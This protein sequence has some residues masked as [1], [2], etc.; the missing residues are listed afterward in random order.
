[1][2]ALLA[3]AGRL[4]SKGM[5][6][7][8]VFGQGVHPTHDCRDYC[9]YCTFRSDPGEPGA[10]RCPRR[11]PRALQSGRKAGRER[12]P[13]LFGDSPKR[14]F[15]AS[16]FAEA[17]GQRTT[18]GYLRDVSDSWSMRPD[19]CRTP[20]PASWPS[21][22]WAPCGRS[23]PAWGSCWRACPSGSLPWRRARS[24]ARQGAG[25]P[26]QDHRARR[27]ARHP[28]HHRHP[29]RHRRDAGDRVARSSPSASS[30]SSTDISRKS[31]SRTFAPSP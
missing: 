25:A 19:S 8:Y 16:R 15:R 22:I 13:L 31:S 12:G 27:Q 24:R 30:T 23:M 29:D 4:I 2:P 10:Q 5:A 7:G 21:A 11:G 6:A 26:A 3:A 14:S 9:G 18:L 17:H 20:T 28:L 1:M